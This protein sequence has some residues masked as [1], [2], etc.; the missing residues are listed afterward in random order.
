[1]NFANLEI[2][3]GL[4]FGLNFCF[5]DFVTLNFQPNFHLNSLNFAF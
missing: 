3:F 4:N 5:A 2:N 1:M